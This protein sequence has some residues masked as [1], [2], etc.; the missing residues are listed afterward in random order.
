MHYLKE[1]YCIENSLIAASVHL[2]ITKLK[3]KVIVKS[4]SSAVLVPVRGQRL[5]TL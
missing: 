4:N 1:C 2:T 3:H 5:I